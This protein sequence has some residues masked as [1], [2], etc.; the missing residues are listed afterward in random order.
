V[1]VEKK[2]VIKADSTKPAARESR[3]KSAKKSVAQPVKPVVKE[4]PKPT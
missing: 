1:V 2:P 4:E 3:S